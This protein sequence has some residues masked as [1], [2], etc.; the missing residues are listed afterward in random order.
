MTATT[1]M[2][3]VSVVLLVFLFLRSPLTRA[4]VSRKGALRST[5]APWVLALATLTV[6]YLLLFWSAHFYA[7]YTAPLVIV[8]VPLLALAFAEQRWAQRQP[9][10]LAAVFALFFCIWD[11]A[12]LHTGR[13][14]N[15]FLITAGYI[16]R[17]FANDRVGAFQSGTDGFF[18]PNVENLDGKLNQGALLAAQERRLPDFIDAEHIDL[19]YDDQ[20]YIHKLPQDYLDREWQPCP[21]PAALPQWVCLKRQPAAAAVTSR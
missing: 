11:V 19:L 16:Q 13:M 20:G 14:G 3:A 17:N 12:S 21:S 4:A 8:S 2:G 10:L 7:R 5:F 9:P 6:I 18:N 1:I 15:N